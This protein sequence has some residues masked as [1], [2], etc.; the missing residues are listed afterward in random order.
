MHRFGASVRLTA[1]GDLAQSPAAKFHPTGSLMRTRNLI[2]GVALVLAAAC[3]P[4][5]TSSAGGPQKL[6]PA[7]PV[8][9]M[10]NGAITA[11]EL[12][13]QVKAE[14]RKLE[15]EH[16]ER[17]YEIRRN[18]LEGLIVKKVVEAKAKAESLTAEEYAAREVLK[19][20]AEPTDEEIRSLYDRAV[21]GG[22]K[23]PPLDKVKA[24]IARFIKQQ[25]G[26]E[27]AMAWYEEL[28]KEA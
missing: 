8:A 22:E 18:A 10:A 28:E 11:G 26:R 17:L 4:A 19:K 9:R 23:L 16:Q 15:T 5:R 27:A 7:A 2:A 3:Q 21:A 12:E 20:V 14:V 6:D 24:E 13:E 1:G 25:K